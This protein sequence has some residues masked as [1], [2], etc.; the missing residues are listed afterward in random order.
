MLDD[1]FIVVR[2]L[3]VLLSTTASVDIFTGSITLVRL[4]RL[5]HGLRSQN[6]LG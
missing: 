5:M 3:R 1:T 6:R 4:T 2:A